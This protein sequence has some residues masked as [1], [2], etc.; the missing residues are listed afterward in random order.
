MSD[1]QKFLDQAKTYIGKNG[2]YVC[3]TKLGYNFIFDWCAASVSAIMKD[4]GF[5][6][7]YMNAIQVGAGDIPRYSDGKYGKWFKKGDGTPQA[8]DLFFIR[9][10]G[11]YTDKYHADHVGIVKS[12]SNNTIATYEGNVD[13]TNGNEWAGT[14]TFKS[15]TRYLS[16]TTMYAFYRPHWNNETNNTPSGGGT[17]DK[18]PST[19]KVSIPK[20]KYKVRTD[21]RW[22]PEVTDLTDF[23]GLIGHPITDIAIDFSHNGGSGWYKVCSNGKW[24]PK[25][26]GYNTKDYHNGYAGD[27]GTISA[28]VAYYNTPDRIAK[29]LGYLKIKYRVSP[30]GRNYYAWQHDNETIN[31]Q[32]GYAGS[33]GQAIDRFQCY[34]IEE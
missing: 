3:K 6:G 31:G 27:G 11:N 19:Q 30:V 28:I 23:A 7:T 18:Q 15:K 32:D 9:Y 25:V 2:S 34:L 20:I 17:T 13:A 5:I 24:L 4:L 29:G 21:G 33:I 26:T 22:L 10:G 8:G 12:V 16:E 1:K 14:S